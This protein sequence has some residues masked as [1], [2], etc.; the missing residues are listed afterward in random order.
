MLFPKNSNKKHQKNTNIPQSR[1]LQ[2]RKKTQYQYYAFKKIIKKYIN[3]KY[4]TVNIINNIIYNEKTHIVAIFKDYLILDDS[5]EFLKRYYKVYESIIRL[6]KFYEY[7]NTYSKIYPN[8]TS[9]HEGKYIYKNILKKQRMIDIQEQMVIKNKQN[10]SSKSFDNEVI[11]EKEKKD[12][13]FSTDVINS[14]LNE[15]NKENIE[16]LFN[17]NR[18]NIK[19]DDQKF[20]EKVV[21]LID[22][23]EKYENANNNAHSYINLENISPEHNNEKN[24]STKNSSFKTPMNVNN[25]ILKKYMNNSITNLKG[26]ISSQLLSKK[27]SK[28][29]NLFNIH[30][31]KNSSSNNFNNNDN[32][33]NNNSKTD[34]AMIEKLEHNLLKLTKKNQL[35][36]KKNTSYSQKPIKRENSSLN[37]NNISNNSKKNVKFK[38]K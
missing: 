1:N 25:N 16:I 31:K 5:S 33:S 22:T 21:D 12:N 20:N 26:N 36:S 24:K 35:Y 17:I 30:S 14:I 15:T 37:K 2:K 19:I 6:P 10:N 34:R 38:I 29:N 18:D 7:Y 4:Y 8:Y 23:I 27:N 13:V 9:L 3:P 28:K 11:N 32:N